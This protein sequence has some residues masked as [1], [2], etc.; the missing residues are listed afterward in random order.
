[1][2]FGLSASTVA[3]IG[4]TAPAVIG[5]LMGSESSG[6]SQTQKQ[7]LDPRLQAMLY[8]AGGDN[9][10]LNDANDLRKQQMA[11]GGLNPMQRTG[12]EMQRQTLMSPQYTQG[13]DQM[14][15]MGA[16]LMGAGV[17]GNPFANGG[18]GYIG[19]GLGF[20]SNTAPGARPMAAQSQPMA[21][22][23]PFQYQPNSA[24]QAGNSPMQM[25]APYTAPPPRQDADRTM[26]DDYL[27]KMM[28]QQQAEASQRGNYGGG[29]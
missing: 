23:Q 17:A 10:L 2:A 26:L 1:M 11:E 16:Q 12:L 28:A 18:N 25:P 8:G 13:F 7:E 29:N 9:G 24:M 19:G 21:P 20:G 4:A 3:L 5:G 14:R 6:S 27:R 15:N 22:M